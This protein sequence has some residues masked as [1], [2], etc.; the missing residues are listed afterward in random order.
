MPFCCWSR[1]HQVIHNAAYGPVSFP[2]RAKIK[3]SYPL[4]RRVLCEKAFAK[5]RIVK[6]LRQA[7]DIGFPASITDRVKL[8]PLTGVI[9]KNAARRCGYWRICPS[10]YSVMLYR[11]YRSLEKWVGKEADIATTKLV[12]FE[13]AW[14]DP[15]ETQIR[16]LKHLC[17]LR[18]RA[19][20][21]HILEFHKI[22]TISN[23]NYVPVPQLTLITVNSVTGVSGDTPGRLSRSTLDTSVYRGL[24]F[25]NIARLPVN[26]FLELF[27]ASALLRRS[28]G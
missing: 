4:F 16:I 10:C 1:A 21:N 14:E 2:L 26:T 24:S 12:P 25:F 23:S 27:K 13:H 19:L 28:N 17:S 8:C 9:A 20:R 11:T 5:D 18:L 22:P 3:D 6:Y 7:E 15:I